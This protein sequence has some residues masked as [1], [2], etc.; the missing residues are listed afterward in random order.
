MVQFNE[1]TKRATDWGQVKQVDSAWV[2][3]FKIQ[4]RDCIA[5][6]NYGPAR[7][8][9]YAWLIIG[10]S[11]PHGLSAPFADSAARAAIATALPLAP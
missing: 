5:F 2:V 3:N 6:D 1:L 9:G 7:F 10:Y 11:C 4:G 8:D